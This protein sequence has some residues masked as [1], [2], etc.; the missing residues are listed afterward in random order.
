MIFVRKVNNL[1][2]EYCKII[3]KYDTNVSEKKVLVVILGISSCF[4][5]DLFG[6]VIVFLFTFV[7]K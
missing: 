5:L 1:H 2:L 3:L 4:L 7:I 6:A